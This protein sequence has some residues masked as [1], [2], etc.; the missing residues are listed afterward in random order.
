MTLPQ[1]IA[2]FYDD[3]TDLWLDSWGEHMHHGYYGPEGK[4]EINHQEAQVDM[5]EALLEWGYLP[6][7]VTRIFDA[8]CGIGAS[9]RYLANRFE[10]ASTLGLTLSPVQAARGKAY[11]EKAGLADRC[12]IRAA[13]VYQTDPEKEG[14]FDL[15]WSMESAEHMGDKPALFDL[16]YRLLRPGGTLLMATWCHRNEPPAL[17]SHEQENLDKLCKLYHLPP[18]TSIPKLAEDAEEAGFK[19]IKTDDWSEG[20]APFWGAVIKESLK[21]KN[22]PGLLRSGTGTLKGAWAMRYMQKGFRE[23]SICYGMLTATK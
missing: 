8:G 1:R 18:W 20:I 17:R 12:E 2:K 11:N 21:P 4:R 7:Q 15:I 6:D 10:R 14:A 16:F 23:G 13:D 9:S 5:I 19:H 22:W 3:S